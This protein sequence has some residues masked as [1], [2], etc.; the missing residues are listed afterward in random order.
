MLSL[1]EI[2]YKHQ[3]MKPTIFTLFLL[4][5]LNSCG[6]KKSKN[7]DPGAELAGITQREKNLLDSLNIDAEVLA[8][9]RTLTD[10][11]IYQLSTSFNIYNDSTGDV[12]TIVKDHPGFSCREEQ[13]KAREI[14]FRL[15]DDLNKNGYLIY[16]SKSNFGYDSDEVSIIKSIDQFDILRIEETDGINYGLENA[17][18]ISRLQE[19]NKQYPFTIVG[20]DLDWV[21]AVFVKPP[22]D[23][24]SFAKEV[25]EFCPD[26]VDQGTGTVDVLEKEMKESGTFF[27]WWD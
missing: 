1:S 4:I 17:G 3:K 25:Y 7:A 13:R 16:V 9:L 15:K 19:W 27:L 11:S 26:V 22:R 21:E 14:V 18:V 23:M 12:E 24:Q 10:S 8:D 20:A 5:I 2:T 6:Q